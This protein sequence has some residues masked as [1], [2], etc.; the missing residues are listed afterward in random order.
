MA[1]NEAQDKKYAAKYFEIFLSRDTY[2][3][4]QH[5]NRKVKTICDPL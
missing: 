1:S 3:D 5:C 4:P 2:D